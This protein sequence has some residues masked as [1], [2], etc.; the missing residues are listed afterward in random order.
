MSDADPRALL[1]ELPHFRGLAPDLLDAIAAGSRVRRF[2]AGAVVFVEREPCKAF[3]A[4]LAGSVKLYRSQPDGREQVVNHLHVG[5][6]F[7]EAALMSFGHYPV[8]AV[9]LE[10]PTELLE[11]GGTPLLRL[12]REDARL[13][14]AMISSLSVRL[15]SLVERVEELSTIQAGE[16]LARWLLRQ[17]ARD[18]RG[19]LEIELGM[20]KKELAAH[21]AMTPETL[22]RLLRR[23]QE[24]GWLESERTFVRVLAV[25]RLSAVADGAAGA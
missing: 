4:V 9:A 11:V 18:A 21:L 8:G 3:F 2:D 15:V 16:R 13:A 25:A 1:R 20:A 14:P 19:A 10:T 7:A 6:T 22:S 12:L 24:E 17:P 5:A 23:W